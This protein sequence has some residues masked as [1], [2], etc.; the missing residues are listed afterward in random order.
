MYID[1]ITFI[2]IVNAFLKVIW[3]WK[4]FEK[5]YVTLCLK[6]HKKQ[7]KRVII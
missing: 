4:V 5:E 1:E 2:E 3:I 7:V 6:M